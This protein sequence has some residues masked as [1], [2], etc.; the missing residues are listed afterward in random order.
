MNATTRFVPAFFGAAALLVGCGGPQGPSAVSLPATNIGGAAFL[1]GPAGCQNGNL[2]IHPCRITFN[3]SNPGPTTVTLGREGNK[4]PITERDDC[5]SA[6]IATV[7]KVKPRL[8]GRGR[9]HRRFVYRT[10][11]Q[12]TRARQQRQT[13]NRQRTLAAFPDPEASSPDNREGAADR[14]DTVAADIADTAGGIAGT[15]NTD[16][17]PSAAA[18]AGS[19]SRHRH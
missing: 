14:A 5:A 10:L 3:A 1:A 11:H 13:E 2:K 17:A 18:L 12:R 7:T 15:A 16:A 8:V 4:L 9:V 6:G 19:R